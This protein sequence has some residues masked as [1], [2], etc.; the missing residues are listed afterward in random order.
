MTSKAQE[1]KQATN[2]FFQSYQERSVNDCVVLEG[3]TKRL[4]K[5]IAALLQEGVLE[6]K[7][8]QPSKGDK[9]PRPKTKG[10]EKLANKWTKY[11]RRK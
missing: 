9:K 2:N 11:P 8:M 1:N 3:F 10:V 7:P 5:E 4:D 6:D